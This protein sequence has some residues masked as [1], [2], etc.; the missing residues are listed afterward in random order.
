MFFE[1]WNLVYLFF[2]YCCV[3]D[4]ESWM[5]CVCVYVC[6]C[7]YVHLCL[8]VSG[9]VSA[10]SALSAFRAH[11]IYYTHW[12]R[13][14]LKMLDGHF[15]VLIQQLMA[16]R[17]S[18]HSN[19]RINI[20]EQRINIYLCT[21]VVD[22]ACESNLRECGSLFSCAGLKMNPYLKPS[23]V[24][25]NSKASVLHGLDCLMPLLPV[26]AHHL[27]KDCLLRCLSPTKA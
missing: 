19:P 18:T 7:G 5:A 17:N 22:P 21:S 25:W 12:K 6:V 24:R 4:T 1:G 9:S 13:R 26:F 27:W 2:F 8:F 15:G 3:T 20:K 14:D 16:G 11:I 10:S 23:V